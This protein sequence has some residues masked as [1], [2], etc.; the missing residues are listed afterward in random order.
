M[1]SIIVDNGMAAMDEKAAYESYMKQRGQVKLSVAVFDPDEYKG[2]V[3]LDD[4]EL[5]S[6]RKEK[7]AHR[8]ENT[9]HLK[10]VVIDEKSGVRD[11][12]VYMDLLKSKDLTAYGQ[13]R[14]WRS[15]TW[16]PQG[17]RGAFQV[18]QTEDPGRL[19]GLA[20]GDVTLPLQGRE[21]IISSFR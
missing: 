4:K 7:S 11:D 21:Q 1:M 16:G 6:L 2:K 3:S 18:R 17:E 19:K 14:A 20:K 9:F 5:D 8:S 15:P 12:Q 13:R 10:Y